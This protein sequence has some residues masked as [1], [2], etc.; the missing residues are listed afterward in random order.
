MSDDRA[1][2][3]SLDCVLANNLTESIFSFSLK[4]A[5]RT[6][7]PASEMKKPRLF[8]TVYLKIPQI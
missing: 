4:K 7:I 1:L 2:S 5:V 3:R 8:G 6:I